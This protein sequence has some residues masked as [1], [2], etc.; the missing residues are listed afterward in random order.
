MYSNSLYASV[1]IYYLMKKTRLIKKDN[2]WFLEVPESV[3]SLYQLKENTPFLLAV[4]ENTKRH[5]LCI[6]FASQLES[7]FDQDPPSR[8]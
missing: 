2:R 1:R 6:S 8:T 5:I 7:D 4:K 3:I